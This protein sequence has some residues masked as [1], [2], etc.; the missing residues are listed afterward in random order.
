MSSLEI[1]VIDNTGWEATLFSRQHLYERTIILEC[2][3]HDA[4]PC[5]AYSAS[6][7]YALWQCGCGAHVACVK[8]P[9]DLRT[10][11]TGRLGA[12]GGED[13]FLKRGVFRKRN[14]SVFVG[15]LY[16]RLGGKLEPREKKGEHIYSSVR[17]GCELLGRGRGR[18]LDNWSS[19]VVLAVPAASRYQN[20]QLY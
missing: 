5:P 17:G 3:S 18:P 7:K 12:I 6:R 14:G 11:V 4:L 16:L 9:L 8:T 13:V 10:V 20:N 19:L 1:V 2:S 15:V